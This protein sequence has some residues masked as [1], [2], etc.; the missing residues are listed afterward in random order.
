M[1]DGTKEYVTGKLIPMSF[2]DKLF[3]EYVLDVPHV[4]VGCSVIVAIFNVLLPG[5][6][7]IIAACWTQTDYVSKL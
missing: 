2:E 5:T 3:F 1:K 7:T 6:G 4:S